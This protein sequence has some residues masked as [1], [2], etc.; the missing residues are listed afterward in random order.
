MTF[1]LET[2][3]GPDLAR[4]VVMCRYPDMPDTPFQRGPKD[5]NTAKGKNRR[6]KKGEN[7]TQRKRTNQK[8]KQHIEIS[9][10]RL[11]F[12][13]FGAF[14]LWFSKLWKRMNM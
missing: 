9:G 12:E 4:C 8:P 11:V 13:V 7:S 6:A 3:Q 2:I 10:P 1:G 5:E 14:G